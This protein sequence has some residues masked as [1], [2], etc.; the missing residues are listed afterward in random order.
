MKTHLR[1]TPWTPLLP[2]AAALLLSAIGAAAQDL[3]TPD[4][5]KPTPVIQDEAPAANTNVFSDVQAI[6]DDPELRAMLDEAIRRD[7]AGELEKALSIY[8]RIHEQA[9]ENRYIAF[10]MGTMLVKANRYPEAL[11][12]LT[13]LL[14]DL[15]GDYFV[16]NN[17]AWIYATSRDPA[18]RNGDKAVALAK[19]A[20]LIAPGDYHV[21]N[22]LSEA[23]Y[24]SAQYEKALRAAE[25]AFQMAMDARINDQEK[26]LNFS[27]QVRKCRQAVIAT[28]LVE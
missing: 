27:Q 1:L 17:V 16:K 19:E 11:E 13:P 7:R 15:P 23:Y 3:T 21:W 26:L 12:L 9:P 5:G 2:I 10:N 8:Q 24:V 6:R 28:S 4:L 22:T 14:D 25:A 18:V 20:L